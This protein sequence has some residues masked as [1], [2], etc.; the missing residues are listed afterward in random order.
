MSI[1]SVDDLKKVTLERL[2]TSP[3]ESDVNAAIEQLA[4]SHPQLKPV[5]LIRPTRKGDVAIIDFVGSIDGVEFPGG[6]GTDYPL[7]LGSGSF[8]P[9]FE[10]QLIDRNVGDVV[11]VRV[12]FP[13]DYHAKELAG[14][15]AVFRTTIKSLKQK[16][17]AVIDD[18][19][20]KQFG[21]SSISEM[22]QKVAE[23]LQESIDAASFQKLRFEAMEKLADLFHVDPPANIV[24]QEMEI[25]QKHDPEISADDA[26][27]A[28][29]RRAAQGIL[30]MELA[31]A[32]NVTLSDDEVIEA[33]KNEVQNYGPQAPQILAFYQKNPQMLAMFRAGEME[34][35]VV[36]WVVDHCSVTEKAVSREEFEKAMEI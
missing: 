7:E 35:K 17:D 10:D 4:A 2:A 25:I 13:K 30:L 29:T 18:E 11:N 24:E 16:K 36:R 5:L 9:G 33:L 28:A 12:P 14:K 23:N 32:N 21:L 20:A 3:T 19:F 27:V 26:R 15:L 34:K 22:R 31:K 8:I 6:S 1:P